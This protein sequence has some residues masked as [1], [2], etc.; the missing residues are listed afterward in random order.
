LELEARHNG[1]SNPYCKDQLAGGVNKI[2]QIF[3]GVESPTNPEF[4]GPLH[5][6]GLE[7]EARHNGT[8]N[9]YCKIN[10]LGEWMHSK[11]IS[12]DLDPRWEEE[13]EFLLDEAPI[14]GVLLLEVWTRFTY[15]GKE[16]LGIAKIPLGDVVR[17]RRILDIYPLD[18]ERS[19]LL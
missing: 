13:F 9:P 14:D 18:G 10:V 11:T 17:N 6:T 5:T 1:T 2:H 12:H 3:V 8:S 7:L 4:S 15:W 16:S 19:R